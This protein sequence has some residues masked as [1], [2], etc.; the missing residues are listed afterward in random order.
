MKKAFTMLEL[1][2]AI[3]IIGI[4]AAVAVP[5]FNATRDDAVVVKALA[6]INTLITD[7]STYYY[8][9]GGRF[10]D[11]VT[12]D[13]NAPARDFNITNATN[14]KE[15]D[16]LGKYSNTEQ[17]SVPKADSQHGIFY[18]KERNKH[19]PCIQFHLFSHEIKYKIADG[20]NPTRNQICKRVIEG[21]GM[22]AGDN[23]RPYKVINLD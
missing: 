16:G 12:D 2:F 20:A 17:N 13:I 8:A 7:L 22:N 3:V 4:L 15:G 9:Q 23:T 1:I 11:G 6:N 21:L 19:I 10:S 18:T 5:K 14:L